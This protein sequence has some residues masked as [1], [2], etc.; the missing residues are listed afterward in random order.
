MTQKTF[1]NEVRKDK[2]ARTMESIQDLPIEICELIDLSL[3][4][5]QNENIEE[6]NKKIMSKILAYGSKD[7][8]KIVIKMQRYL[9]DS[10]GKSI[11]SSLAL[12]GLLIAQLKYDLSSEVISPE[13]YFL[14][15]ITDYDKVKEEIRQELNNTVTDLKLNKQFMVDI[16]N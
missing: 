14:L 2:I 8:I 12:Y 1:R 13:S 10:Q 6:K 3:K 15:R 5:T 9:Y 4:K 16:N 7:A 11:N